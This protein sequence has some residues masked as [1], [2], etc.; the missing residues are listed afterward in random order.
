MSDDVIDLLA[1]IEPGS[2]LD[3]VRRQ[4]EAARTHAQASF[5]G[6]F[7]PVDASGFSVTER[8]AVAAFLAL[9]HNQDDAAAF[10]AEGLAARDAVLAKVVRGEAG[11]AAAR[12][13]F[14]RFPAGPL[15]AEDSAGFVHRADAAVLG[16]R[17]AAALDHA[18][19]LLFHPR[20]AAP[21]WL[22]RLVDAGWTTPAIVTLS[23]LVAFLSFQIRVVAGLRAMQ[24][25]A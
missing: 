7:A 8:W 25:A 1:G 14:G 2:G 19:M 5:D 18:H 21:E 13:P 11:R 9:L 17:L 16:R 3:A 15:T 12:G 10:Y 22:Q 20:D 23:Q 6:L 4:R 24:H